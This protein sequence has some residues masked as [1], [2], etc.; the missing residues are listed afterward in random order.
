MT[1]AKINGAA[2]TVFGYI[3]QQAKR[4][5]AMGRL[6]TGETYMQTLRSFR[7]FRGGKDLDFA[8]FDAD[9]VEQ[10]ESYLRGRGL[11][12]NSTSF[13]MRVLRC[14][15]NRAVADGLA[16]RCQPFSNVYT[17]VDKTAKRALTL[18]DLQRIKALDLTTRPDL[19][20]ARDVFL[21][22]FYMRGMSFIDIAYLRKKDLSNGYV[23]YVRRKT[24]QQLRVRWERYMQ[25]IVDK[26]PDN[27]TVYM[28]PIITRESV[29]ERRQYLNKLLYINRK[30]KQIGQLARIPIP[31]SMYVSRHSWASIAR[32]R[33]VPM[34]IIC[35]GL[36]HDN[37]ETTRIYL[38]EIESTGIDNANLEIMSKL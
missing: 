32:S 5:T 6:R 25:A 15:Y 7:H 23:S 9:I 26:Y 10:Y 19:D 24:G 16:P 29:A 34:S 30:L 20:Y 27:D 36:G 31:L 11:S 4:K 35:E 13:Y 8:M 21:F 38:A 12:R 14:I 1:T 37:E 33:N 17:G 2:V 18:A 28:L 3:G 22:S